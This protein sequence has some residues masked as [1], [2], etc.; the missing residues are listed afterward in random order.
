ML[1]LERQA[2]PHVQQRFL[3]HRFVLEDAEHRL[4]AIEQRMARPLDVARRQRVEHLPIGL[5]GKRPNLVSRRP[6][7]PQ[8]RMLCF[9][10][11]S[12]VVGID[13]ARE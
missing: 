9:A 5:S 3:M 4:G 13:A 1:L 8:F 7:R 12:E 6:T 10:F 2:V 11:R